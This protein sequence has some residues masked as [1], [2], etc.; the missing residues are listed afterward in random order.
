[1]RVACLPWSRLWSLARVPLYLLW[2]LRMLA[3]TLAGAARGSAW[4]R[5]DRSGS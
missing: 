5:T 2:K 3:T 1:M 4:I